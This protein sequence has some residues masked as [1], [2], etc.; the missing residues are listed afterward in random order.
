MLHGHVAR[1]LHF[2]VQASNLAL[3]RTSLGQAAQHLDFL[4]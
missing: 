2:D 3:V 4:L 1:L